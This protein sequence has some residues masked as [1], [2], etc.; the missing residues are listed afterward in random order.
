MTIK[1]QKPEQ[2]SDE[3]LRAI[4]ANLPPAKDDEHPWH[5]AV[6][7]ELHSR[8]KAGVELIDGA[9]SHHRV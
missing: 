2:L 6:R 3:E 7:D 8:Q 4:V 1:W 5:Q 9:V